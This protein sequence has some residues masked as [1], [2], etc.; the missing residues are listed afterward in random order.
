MS[1]NERGGDLQE[2]VCFVRT[3]AG[4]VGLAFSGGRLERLHLPCARKSEARGAFLREGIRR[5]ETPL[6]SF[7]VPLAETLVRYFAGE[8]IDPARVRVPLHPGRITTFRKAVYAAL[9]RTRLGRVTTYGDLARRAGSPGAARAVGTAL[10]RNPLPLVIPCH[11]VLGSD[12][13]LHGFSAPGG[14]ETKRRL[15]ELEGIL[16]A[17]T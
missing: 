5:R 4:Y 8:R 2:G 3:K 14:L 7:L 13:G 1:R 17:T 12:G 11:R 15:L 16:S 9:R 6:P 10:A